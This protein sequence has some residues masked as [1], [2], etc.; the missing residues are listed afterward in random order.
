[1]PQQPTW[2]DIAR[3]PAERINLA[4]AALVIA[5]EEYPDLDVRTYLKRIDDMA[6][7]LRKRLR[8]DIGP[9]DTLRA[10]NRY[11]FEELGY[12]GNADD[13]YD[14]RNSY[15]NELIDRR[16]GIPITLSVLYIEVGQRL[17]LTLAG[18]SFPGHFLVKCTLRDGAVVIDPYAKGESLG[19]RDLQQRLR[20]LSGVDVAPEAVMP[21]LAAAD[22]RE[23]LARML[24]NLKEIY[25]QRG[26]HARALAVAEQLVVLMPGA[27][28]EIRDRGMLYEAMECF[29]AAL[30]DLETYLRLNPEAEDARA[31]RARIR[32]LRTRAS[33]LN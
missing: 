27:A 12:A 5:A 17:G 16:L 3:L 13:Y 22:P 4:E 25:K 32:A 31:V 6:A 29:R 26:D 15:L 18:V 2:H 14:P 20:T 28:I 23:I 11:L 24:R 7:D 8:A 21:M 30:V 1:M 19:I 9:T 10:L 33:R